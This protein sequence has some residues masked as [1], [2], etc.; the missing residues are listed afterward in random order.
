MKYDN[1][2]SKSEWFIG[3]VMALKTNNANAIQKA[4]GDCIRDD[5]DL[6]VGT[7][8]LEDLRVDPKFKFLEKIKAQ[9]VRRG[10]IAS[11]IALHVDL[12]E[13][14]ANMEKIE[15]DTDENK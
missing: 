2:Y 7:A 3:C 10:R 6:D 5:C 4:I 12:C 14:I 11:M 9:P 8:F 15:D 1:A 13:M